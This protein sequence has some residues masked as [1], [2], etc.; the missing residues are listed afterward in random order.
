[1]INLE[2][3]K[4]N[5]GVVNGEKGESVMKYERQGIYKYIINEEK[6]VVVC[7]FDHGMKRALSELYMDLD[8]ELKLSPFFGV[9]S[10]FWNDIMEYDGKWYEIVEEHAEQDIKVSKTDFT[11]NGILRAFFYKKYGSI[12]RVPTFKGIARCALGIDTFDKEIGKKIAQLRLVRAYTIFV[13]EFIEECIIAQRSFVH[14]SIKVRNHAFADLYR[15]EKEVI[16]M[17][18]SDDKDKII[19]EST[20]EY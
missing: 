11:V 20:F 17:L 6:G 19:E 14:K 7:V 13:S 8:T 10:R 4:E 1:M 3:V 12:Y 18:D 9:F 15:L 2:K 16:N 5:T